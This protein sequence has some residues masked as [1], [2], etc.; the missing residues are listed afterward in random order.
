[1]LDQ[2]MPRPAQLE[3]LAQAS[4]ALHSK[5]AAAETLLRGCRSSFDAKLHQLSQLQDESQRLEDAA[6]AENAAL[7]EQVRA[8]SAGRDVSAAVEAIRESDAREISSLSK[9][10]EALQARLASAKKEK[11][12]LQEGSEA[13]GAGSPAALLKTVAGL[14][15]QVRHLAC[16]SRAPRLHLDCTST[17]PRA[18]LALTSRSPRAH[19]ALISR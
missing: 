15:E 9:Q 2:M 12:R 8:V 6:A 4:T 11:A 14:I 18:D 10:V 19:L 3:K 16:T 5:V 13:G 7:R 1:M 17:A